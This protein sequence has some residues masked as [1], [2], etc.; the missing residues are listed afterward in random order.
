MLRESIDSGPAVLPLFENLSKCQLPGPSLDLLDHKLV[1]VLKSFYS[2]I[3]TV[4]YVSKWD[5]CENA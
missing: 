3:L 2:T 1:S 5:S 4:D